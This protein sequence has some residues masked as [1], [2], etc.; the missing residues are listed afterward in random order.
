MRDLSD[1]FL[2][3]SYRNGYVWHDLSEDDVIQPTQGAE[4]VLKGSELLHG[5]GGA[6]A[7]CSHATSAASSG[8]DKSSNFSESQFS[9]LRRNKKPWHSF[10]LAEYKVFKAESTD[11][12]SVKAADASTQTDERRQWRMAIQ[13]EEQI[14]SSVPDHEELSR[15][16]ISPP[17]SSSSPDTLETLIR[18][19]VIAAAGGLSLRDQ[20]HGTGNH[21]NV[22]TRASQMLMHLISCGSFSVKD[23][24]FSLVSQYR[25]RLPH[26]PELGAD[27]EEIC[28]DN[29]RSRSIFPALEAKEYFSGS[30]IE[31]K[32]GDESESEPPLLKR[33]SSFN[34]ERCCFSF[35]TRP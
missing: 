18:A 4:Y 10:E 31:T 25:S 7:G 9:P 12:S 8:S 34:A 24:G 5:D 32:K 15:E 1:F 16:E 27:K 21:S 20:E 33:S 11:D 29:G 19:D 6:A 26:R 3:R 2:F 22:R 14:R 17:P 35:S 23:H 28:T 30:L 13:R